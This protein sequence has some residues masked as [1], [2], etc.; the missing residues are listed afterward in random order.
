[1]T[2]PIVIDYSSRDQYSSW[3]ALLELHEIHPYGWTLIGGQMVHLHCWE[4]GAFSPRVTT[5]ADAGL[6]LR[7]FPQIAA[8]LTSALQ[9]LGF[10][11]AGTTMSDIQHRWIRTDADESRAQLDVVVAHSTGHRARQRT[12]AAGG[13]PLES[14][15]IQQALER[16]ETVTVS[17]GGV[18]GQVNRPVLLGGL[19]GKAAALRNAGDNPARHLEDLLTLAALLTARD[20]Q[21]AMNK[22]DREHLTYAIEQLNR[23]G[24][25]AGAS[26]QQT[27]GIRLVEV[28]LNR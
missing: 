17:L 7:G 6:D 11:L 4:R 26:V 13:R 23:Q 5:D 14:F 25:L 27:R 28:L 3:K 24:L 9:E 22:R 21:T 2:E 19:V 18:L 10:Q 20:F 15:G 12:T 16:S 8:T 1:M